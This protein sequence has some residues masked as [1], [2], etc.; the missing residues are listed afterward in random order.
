MW[1]PVAPGHDRGRV[2]PVGHGTEPR[3]DVEHAA[4]RPG[5][6]AAQEEE[7]RFEVLVAEIPDRGM[8]G[9]GTSVGR[10]VVVGGAHRVER[11]GEAGVGVVRPGHQAV[12][13]ENHAVVR[14]EVGHELREPEAR[15]Q[16]VEVGEA[17]AEDLVDH[18]APVRAVGQRADRVGVDVVHVRCRQERVEERLDGRA[19]RGGVD[20]RATHDPD[21]VGVVDRV[22]AAERLQ[23]V[24]PQRGVD[25]GV[26]GREV[27]ARGLD[28]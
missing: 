4:P 14:R 12:V 8:P 24:D 19:R 28:P 18:V 27:A 9:G 2:F 6:G 1:S 13:R 25:R 7:Q 22:T 10:E 11:P 3:V 23:L 16:P 17:L 21:H 15:A 5:Q 26:A 20:Q